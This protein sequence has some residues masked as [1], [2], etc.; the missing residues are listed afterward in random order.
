[1]TINQL[2]IDS[3]E[4]SKAHGFWDDLDDIPLGFIISTKLALVHSEISEA[5][6]E[7]RNSDTLDSLTQKRYTESGKLEGLGSELADA[8]IRIADLAGYLGIDLEAVIDE[9]AA[10]NRGRPFKH[11][12]TI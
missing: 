8:I 3:H 5:L 6:E 7:V 1:M 4:N 2:V 9:K 10:Y 11:G 12:R